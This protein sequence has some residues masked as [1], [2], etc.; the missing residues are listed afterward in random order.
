MLKYVLFDLDE[1]LYPTSNGLMQAIGERM[2]EYIA[3]K[4]QLSP[5]DALA[6]QKRYWNEYGTTL[7]GLYLE[8]DL[9]PREYL[10][11]VHDVDLSKFL[12]PDP[13]LR[14]VLQLIPQEKVIVTNA[15]ADHARGVLAALGVT[16]LFTRIF[17]IVFMEYES[18]PARGAYTR[19]LRALDAS[20]GECALVEDSARNLPPARALGIRS[21]LLSASCDPDIA[22]LCIPHISHVANAIQTLS[23]QSLFA[24]G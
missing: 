8:K 6:L 10:E 1:T 7:R 22:D 24:S 9:E 18:K 12:A 15:D 17:D 20:G 19:V 23:G 4:Y 14:S 3:K 11:Y 5:E 21:I 13:A 2:R 16:D